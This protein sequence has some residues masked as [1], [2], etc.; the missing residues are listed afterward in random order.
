MTFPYSGGTL[1]D[2]WTDGELVNAAAMKSRTTDPLNAL[3]NALLVKTARVSCDFACASL[4]IASATTTDIPVTSI[5]AQT[6]GTFSIAA[7]KLVLPANGIY[8]ARFSGSWN[9]SMGVTRAFIEMRINGTGT[10]PSG[11]VFHGVAGNNE[12]VFSY[13]GFTVVTGASDNTLAIQAYQVTGTSKTPVLMTGKI[14]K[15]SD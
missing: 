1:P 15:I 6:G 3:A 12:D 5:T 10:A 14:V 8:A 13:T 7:G 4:A 11:L 9:T 2:P